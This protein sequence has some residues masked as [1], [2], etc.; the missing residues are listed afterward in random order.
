MENFTPSSPFT[1][2]FRCSSLPVSYCMMFTPVAAFTA[3]TSSAGALV[4]AM[5]AAAS[6]NGTTLCAFAS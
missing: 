3:A 1:S 6:L 2:A 4:G 5:M